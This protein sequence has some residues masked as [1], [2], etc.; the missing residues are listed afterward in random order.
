VSAKAHTRSPKSEGRKKAETRNPNLAKPEPNEGKSNRG[1]KLQ[2]FCVQSKEDEAKCPSMAS[3]FGIRPS[4]GFRP[5]EFGFGRLAAG[6]TVQYARKGEIFLPLTRK[7]EPHT[8]VIA[9]LAVRV[10][11][12]AMGRDDGGGGDLA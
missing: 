8:P 11:A 5:S 4:F 2:P 7:N 12:S 10:F 6:G 3:G 9:S 1:Y